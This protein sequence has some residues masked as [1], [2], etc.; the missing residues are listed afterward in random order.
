MN[1]HELFGARRSAEFLTNLGHVLQCLC[2]WC[3]RVDFT[4]GIHWQLSNFTAVRVK[5]WLPPRWWDSKCKGVTR[6]Q[7]WTRAC[8]RAR[9]SWNQALRSFKFC[10]AFKNWST[11]A[12]RV[13]RALYQW[14]FLILTFEVWTSNMTIEFSQKLGSFYLC[15]QISHNFDTGKNLATIIRKGIYCIILNFL[16]DQRKQPVT[17]TS[18]IIW[19]HS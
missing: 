10:N 1:E 4:T 14:M 5:S 16:S 18:N 6:D 9:S 15:M 13:R 3:A 12:R 8:Q 11:H 17:I 7:N 2:G 19:N